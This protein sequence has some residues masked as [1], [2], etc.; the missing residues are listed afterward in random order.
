M[1]EPRIAS[2]DIFKTYK[3]TIIRKNLVNA[4]DLPIIRVRIP[5]F[6]SKYN[7]L[8]MKALEYDQFGKGDIGLICAHVRFCFRDV[9]RDDSLVIKRYSEDIHSKV[10]AYLTDYRKHNNYKKKFNTFKTLFIAITQN[11]FNIANKDFSKICRPIKAN[12]SCDDYAK[13][14]FGTINKLKYGD[15]YMYNC[16][17]DFYLRVSDFSISITTYVAA[18]FASLKVINDKTTVEYKIVRTEVSFETFDDHIV[19]Y[20]ACK[21]EIPRERRTADFMN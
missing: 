15:T 21:L 3:L 11:K 5:W 20:A 7:N 8:I 4:Y 6:T 14:F 12:W 13:L 1:N 18:K 9:Y 2:N 16:K 17:V 19:A 10:L